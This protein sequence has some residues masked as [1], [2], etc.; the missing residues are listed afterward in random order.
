M[1]GP[2]ADLHQPDPSASIHHCH[3]VQRML[4]PGHQRDTDGASGWDHCDLTHPQP[5]TMKSL[6]VSAR[7]MVALEHAPRRHLRRKSAQVGA[8]LCQRRL[9]A[10][11]PMGCISS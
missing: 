11:D 6:V 2:L 8:K 7:N 5:S 9:D 1:R 10:R 3:V 4:I